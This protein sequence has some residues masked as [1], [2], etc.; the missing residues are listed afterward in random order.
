MG[1]PHTCH[2]G[3]ADECLG[4]LDTSAQ[5]GWRLSN[6]SKEVLDHARKLAALISAPS[7][8]DDPPPWGEFDLSDTPLPKPPLENLGDV[9]RALDALSLQLEFGATRPGRRRGCWRDVYADRGKRIEIYGKV[10]RHVFARMRG[11]MLD[12]HQRSHLVAA[13]TDLA[14]LVEMD[15]TPAKGSL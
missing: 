3:A 12:E 9:S 2:P 15:A 13:F 8:S 5:R 7:I 14:I 1:R 10:L 11:E 6:P 4:C